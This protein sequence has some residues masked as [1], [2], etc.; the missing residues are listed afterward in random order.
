MTTLPVPSIEVR[1][2]VKR[3]E[4]TLAVDDLSF[5][6]SGGEILGMVGPNGA[7]KTSTLRCMAGILRPSAGTVRVDG[8]DLAVEPALAKQGL[9]FIPDEPQLFPYLT[10]TEHL[11]FIGRAYDVPTPD[12][13]ITALLGELELADKRD[14]F[15]TELSRGMRQKLAIACGLIHTPR[16]LILDEPLTGLDPAGIKRMK[17]HIVACAQGG[18]AVVLSSHLLH[19]VQELCTHLL[20]VQRGRAVASGTMAEVMALSQGSD[21]E[22]VFLTLTQDESATPV[23]T[24]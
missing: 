16:V 23:S 17:G 9:A 19:L 7:G 6:V 21:L 22:D 1:H 10:V 11:R 15:P 20:V 24:T 8:H 4:K 18:A 12:T 5:R 14:A 13:R 2:L 3:Y